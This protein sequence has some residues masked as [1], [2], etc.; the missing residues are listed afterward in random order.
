MIFY[1]LEE[2]NQRQTQDFLQEGA[3]PKEGDL[4]FCQNLP[5]PERK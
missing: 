4:L 2:I 5:K 3:N 1:Q